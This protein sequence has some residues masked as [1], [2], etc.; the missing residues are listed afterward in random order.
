MFWGV[1]REILCAGAETSGTSLLI[2]DSVDLLRTNKRYKCLKQH[3]LLHH[4]TVS[5]IKV[6]EVRLGRLRLHKRVGDQKTGK[7]QA[8]EAMPERRNSATI[9]LIFE[10]NS[11][12][13]WK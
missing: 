7:T 13:S 10:S 4:C 5:P 9:R 11:Y 6:V 3:G 12:E 2:E 8:D 1:L